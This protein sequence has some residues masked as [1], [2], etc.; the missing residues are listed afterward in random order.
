MLSD[1]RAYFSYICWTKTDSG[2]PPG[3][4]NTPSARVAEATTRLEVSV[5]ILGVQVFRCLGFSC[6]GRYNGRDNDQEYEKRCLINH[7]AASSS[8]AAVY[9]NICFTYVHTNRYYY[10]YSLNMLKDFLPKSG[11][12]GHFCAKISHTLKTSTRYKT[13]ARKPPI[14]QP[15]I[16]PDSGWKGQVHLILS[17]SPRFQLILPYFEP[18]RGHTLVPRHVSYDVL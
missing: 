18:I 6:N 9:E 10:P 15:H 12:P 7:Q 4:R 17:T 5:A 16:V 3:G 11:I 2:G 13:Q 1:F 8:T 14:G